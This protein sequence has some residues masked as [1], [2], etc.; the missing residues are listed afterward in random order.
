M[1]K[2]NN[3]FDFHSITV[4]PEGNTHFSEKLIEFKKFMKP[5]KKYRFLGITF[6]ELFN[7]ISQ[8]SKTDRVKQWVSYLR[9]RYIVD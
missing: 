1:D 7:A 8:F 4:Y 5:E 3:Y 2:D 6:E 9:A